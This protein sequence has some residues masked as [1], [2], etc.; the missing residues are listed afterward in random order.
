MAAYSGLAG[1]AKVGKNC[2]LAGDVCIVG[3]VDVCDDVR[4]LE[5]SAVVIVERLYAVAIHTFHQK[6][7]VSPEM[8]S[9]AELVFGR[10]S[11]FGQVVLFRAALG[12]LIWRRMDPLANVGDALP[13]LLGSFARGTRVVCLFLDRLFRSLHM[14]V[15]RGVLVVIHR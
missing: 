14:T 12:A 1:S 5:S 9:S 11:R 8:Q 7:L 6:L 2:I 13:S 3:H 10:R 4:G 15:C